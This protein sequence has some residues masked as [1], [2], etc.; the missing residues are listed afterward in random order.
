MR[1][2]LGLGSKAK[3]LF[4]STPAKEKAVKGENPVEGLG[5]K[6]KPAVDSGFRYSEFDGKE[7]FFDTK[8]WL[9][10]DCEDDF[11]SV[12]GDFTPSRG[13]TPDHHFSTE[14][15][16]QVNVSLHVPAFADNKSEPS[17]TDSKKK[18]FDLL[19]ETSHDDNERVAE[20][21]GPNKPANN[22][23]KSSEGS[24]YHSGTNS[25]WSSEA[26]PGRDSD[27]KKERT[28]RLRHCCFPGLLPSH[29][30]NE[31]RKPKMSPT[32]KAESR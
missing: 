9:D 22:Y 4:L 2:H 3:R 17:P 32:S 31:R 16:P 26:T 11:M 8:A 14:R 10:S 7:E 21:N 19:R 30:F 29:S 1:F 23:P 12:K 13:N 18:L 27:N 20:T 6:S 25:A 24:P 28:R 15:A 5:F